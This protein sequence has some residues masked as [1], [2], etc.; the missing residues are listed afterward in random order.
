MSASQEGAR[1]DVERAFG[2]FQGKWHITSRPGK[3]W[4]KKF[5]SVVIK[6]C[7]ILH[8]IGFEQREEEEEE[9]DRP[10][11]EQELSSNVNVGGEATP[12]LGSLQHA[13]G[14][15]VSPSGSLATFWDLY[16]FTMNQKKHYNMRK[17][18]MDH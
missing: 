2:I 5:M 15:T 11:N 14:S 4:Y 6:C 9:E 7:I 12:M 13:E 10:L 8:S 17:M 3:Y 18:I 16:S 1:K